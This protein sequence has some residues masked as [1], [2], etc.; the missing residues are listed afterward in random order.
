MDMLFRNRKFKFAA[1]TWLMGNFWLWMGLID[2]PA[3]TNLMFAILGC[4]AAGSV[5]DKM[6][7]RK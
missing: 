4:Y 2:G 5:G 7:M 3:Y 6:A 1:V